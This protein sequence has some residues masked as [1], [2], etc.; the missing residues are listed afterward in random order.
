MED[1]QRETLLVDLAT[2][3]VTRREPGLSPALRR[4]EARRP[5][6][7]QN[8]E[9]GSLCTRFFLSDEGIV[10]LDPVTGGRTVLVRRN[11]THEN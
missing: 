8:P 11:D 5:G 2:G 1:R 7:S 3:G 4:W 10:L 6:D 9:P